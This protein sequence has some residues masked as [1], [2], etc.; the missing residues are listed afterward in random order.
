MNM[1][2]TQPDRIELPCD[3]VIQQARQ[4]RLDTLYEQDGRHDPTHPQHATYCGL[5]LKYGTDA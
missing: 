2:A 5:G 3:P 4:D 1:K